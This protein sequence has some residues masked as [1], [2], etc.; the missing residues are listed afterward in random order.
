MLTY[1]DKLIISTSELK[2]LYPQFDVISL[3]TYSY[4]SL[5]MNCEIHGQFS[6]DAYEAKKGNINCPKCLGVPEVT[7]IMFSQVLETVNDKYSL[8]VLSPKEVQPIRNEMAKL[9]QSC[10]PLCNRKLEMP[11]LDHF[12]KKLNKGNGKVRLVLCRNCNSFLGKVENALPRYRIPN[13]LAPK[14]M[15]NI[16]HYMEMGTTLLVHPSEKEFIKI[17]RTQFN[18][19]KNLVQSKGVTFKYQYP[20]NGALRGK[21]LEYFLEYEEVL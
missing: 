18:K 13:S 12:H 17:T 10:C 7:P 21:L 8:R 2:K 3:P 5:Q 14:V 6:C 20:K 19:L 16:A 4:N 11:V 9:Q 1:E 15:R